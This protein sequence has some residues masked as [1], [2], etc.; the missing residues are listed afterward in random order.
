MI[1][2]GID[3]GQTNDFTAHAIIETIDGVSYLRFIDRYNGASYVDM[4]KQS[5]KYIHD[6]MGNVYGDATGAASPAAFEIL[7]TLIE[8]FPVSLTQIKITSGDSI[9]CTDYAMTVPRGILIDGLRIGIQN[10]TV[11]IPKV[12]MVDGQNIVDVLYQELIEF[13][14]EISASGNV[15]FKHRPNKHDDL[16]FAFALAYFGATQEQTASVGYIR[17]FK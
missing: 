7:Q 17:R 12:L 3:L 16:L 15:V 2:H 9:G 13:Q 11:K 4:M 14:S 5:A 1:T 10:K 6:K 8:P